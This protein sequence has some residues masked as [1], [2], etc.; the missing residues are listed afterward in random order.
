MAVSRKFQTSPQQAH[1]DRTEA[2]SSGAFFLHILLLALLFLFSGFPG[3]QA[4]SLEEIKKSGKIYIGFTS[5]DLKN[6][7]YPLGVEFARYLNV[8]LIPVEIEWEDAFRTGGNI[9]ENL[10]TDPDLVYT[11]DIFKKVDAIFSTF[12][13]LEWRKKLF[14]FA[15]T[16]VSAELLVIGADEPVPEDFSQI[17]GKTVAFME[18]TSFQ[19]HLDEINAEIGGGI[20]YHLTG[21]GSEGKELLLEGKV[22]GLVLDADEALQFLADHPGKFQIALPISP[23]S[24]T[25]YAVEKN[26]PLRNE[27]ENFFGTIAVNGVLDRIYQDKFGISYSDFSQ[28]V[29]RTARLQRYHRD[30]DGILRDGKLVVALRERN[31]IYHQ[32]GNKQFM[33]ALAEE[34]AD[35]LGVELDYVITPDFATYW[36]TDKGEIRKDSAYTPEW[37]NYFDLACEVI[38]PLPWREKMVDLV[39]V[40]PSEYAVVAG[41]NTEIHSIDDLRDLKGVTGKGTIYEEILQKNGISNLVYANVNDFLDMVSRGEADYT[42]IYNAFFELGA[43]PDLESKLSLGQLDV[44][45]ALRKDQPQLEQELRKFLDWSGKQGLIRSLLKAIRGKT[46]QSSDDFIRSFYES[47]QTGQLP[48]VLYGAEDGL[49]QED[50]FSIFQ[51]SLGYMWFGTN[52]GVVRYN[53]REMELINSDD[54]LPDNSIFDI[55]QDRERKIYFATARGVAVYEQDTITGVLFP[56]T[57]VRSVFVDRNNDKWFLAD[58][59]IYVFDHNRNIN[60]L[61]LEL[62]G[63][64]V[65]IFDIVEDP[66][67][68]N[69]IISTDEGLFLITTGEQ[70]ESRKLSP[71]LCFALFIDQNDS[72]WMATDKGLFISGLN[73]LEKSGAG[74][75]R[76][77]N[78]I[79]GVNRLVKGI[80][81]NKYGSVW[82]VTDS[83]IYQVLST[84]QQAV[85]FEQELG[86][87][88]NKILA[89]W[90]DQEDNIWIGFS[91]GLQRLSNKKGL[92]NFYPGM[93]NTYIYSIFQDRN[94]RL[95]IASNNGLY[96]FKDQLE[97]FNAR[98][99]EGNQKFMAALLPSGNILLASSRNLYEVDVESLKLLRSRHFDPPLLDLENLLVTTKGEIFLL[100]GVNGSVYHLDGINGK[101]NTYNNKLTSGVFQLVETSQGVVGGNLNGLIRYDG[102][103]FQ[104]IENWNCKIWS[105]CAD[106]D[107]LWLGTE[108]GLVSYQDGKLEPVPL[109]GSTGTLVIKSI[110][111]AKH[112]NFLWLGTNNGFSYFNK[113][114]RSEEFRIDSNDGLP[115]DEITSG[116]L[117]LDRNNLLW[118]GTYHGLS[119]FNIRARSRHNLAPLCYIER[120]LMN[121]T[122]ISKESGRVFSHNENNLVF[123]I[124][125]LSYSDERSIEYEFYLRGLENDY[126]SY[127]KGNEFRAYYTN[128]PPGRY[129][130]IYKAKGKNNIWSYAQKYSFTIRKAWYDTWIFRIAVVLVILLGAWA[131]YKIRIRSLEAERKKLD[132]LV[133]ERTRDL[134]QANLEI[135]AQRD[136][137]EAQRDQ[138]AQ[139]KKEITDSISY[140]ERIQRSMLPARQVLESL[141]PEHFVYF[142]PRD[143]VSGDFYW[144][145]EKSGKIYVAAVDCTGHGVPGAFMSMLGITFLNEIMVKYNC[146]DAAQVV[147][148]LRN[149]IIH[150]LGQKGVEGEARDGMD[151]SLVIIDRENGQLEFT[152]ANN[153][154]YLIHQGELTEIKGDKMPVAIHPHMP[155]FSLHRLD[156]RPGDMIYLFSDGFADQFGGDEGKKYMYRPFKALLLEIHGESPEEQEKILDRRFEEWK[157]DFEQ[158]DDVVI[159]G[160]RL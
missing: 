139:Q 61:N 109:N 16:L 26:N 98:L 68:G 32:G 66:R 30:L 54:G 79:L 143:I 2:H 58:D 76:K 117:Y 105:V 42:I 1:A 45:W 130:F 38:A 67:S 91:G 56:N 47:F 96:H 118:V 59:G 44:S 25:A 73:E 89:L 34:F 50:V 160:I 144:A 48:Y 13:V 94:D 39:G 83:E 3:L 19:T 86:L 27:I 128:L 6:I 29:S 10:E 65:N 104:Q 97:L 28:Q 20:R 15:E 156:F 77:L 111:Q 113:S 52:S 93:I 69:K 147:G 21:A 129:E 135:E 134:E 151:L 100:T 88:N 57:S 5:D 131:A 49:P 112:R 141:L 62:S 132:A 40:Y 101:L 142:R 22:Y 133:K 53:G 108:C 81:Q 12:T 41:K 122:E 14:D 35:Y 51:D 92:R 159:I 150:A 75:A 60:H 110:L 146:T 145:A 127:N 115:G 103:G 102:S 90:V 158:I 37:F 70:L 7:N 119:N 157:G 33:H 31:F 17:S 155:P 64:P 11:P 148:Q 120:I 36:K 87:K 125:G 138:I 149:E 107:R 140:A 63:L 43:Y 114:T 4:R 106:G 116:G 84:D 152:G 8:K 95:W 123:E 82:L 71:E 137:A 99:P 154:L 18:G 78:G 80:S 46:L 23:I 153:P 85:R 121:G 72:I 126:S 124:T 24:K 55:E 74:H 136:M 9:P